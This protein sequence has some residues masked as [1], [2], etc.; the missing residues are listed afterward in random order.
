MARNRIVIIV[1]FIII[2]IGGGTWYYISRIQP[3]Q[4]EKV[5]QN[6]KEYEGEVVTLEGEVTDRTSFFV[7]LK[8]FKLKDKT[9]EITVVTKKSLPDLK[10]KAIVKGRI[11]D[12]FSLGD[13]KLMVFVEESVETK[14]KKK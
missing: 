13:Q 2:A 7:V 11:D 9:G 4:I 14:G 10:S 1:I 6:P 3:T 5:L 12:A 8:F